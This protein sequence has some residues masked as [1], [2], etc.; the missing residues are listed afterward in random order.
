MF[1]K[2]S[3]RVKISTA[4]FLNIAMIFSWQKLWHLQPPPILVF[5]DYFS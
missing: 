4:L 2:S 3:I 5:Q 1:P